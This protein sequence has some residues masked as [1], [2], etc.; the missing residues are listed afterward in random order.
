MFQVNFKLLLILI[1]HC[2]V[3]IIFL[4]QSNLINSEIF[5]FILFFL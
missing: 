4:I 3:I 2:L 5:I 1:L